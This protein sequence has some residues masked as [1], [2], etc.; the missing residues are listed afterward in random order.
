MQRIALALLVSVFVFG[1]A[2]STSSAGDE[3]P[4]DARIAAL[5][6]RIQA[7]QQQIT[8]LQQ[9]LAT[10]R[11]H[12]AP[13]TT[14]PLTWTRLVDVEHLT[15][16]LAV[17]AKEKK[18]AVVFVQ[19]TWCSY[20]KAYKRLIERDAAVRLGFEGLV[21]LEIDVEREA[22]EDFRKAIGLGAGHPKIVFFDA[23]GEPRPEA[24]IEG[25]HSDESAQ[26]LKKSLEKIAR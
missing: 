10:L 4:A 8:T 24:A 18:P 13:Q 23:T 5:E 16:R 14:K 12:P 6:K 15:S 26:M 22:R 25:W 1:G 17:A 9:Q 19:A 2:T 3:S 11:A 7:L 21:R 20:C